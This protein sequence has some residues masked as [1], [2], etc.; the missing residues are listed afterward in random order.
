MSKKNLIRI[1]SCFVIIMVYYSCYSALYS[2]LIKAGIKC[3]I[4][5][6]SIALMG[7]IGFDK[8][9]IKFMEK[10]KDDRTNV[11]YYLKEKELEDENKVKE[12]LLKCKNIGNEID[13][14]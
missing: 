2:I 1:L 10:L 8:E 7:M 5:S 4:H 3:E 12:F 14:Q 9:D 6:C 11:Q 13:V